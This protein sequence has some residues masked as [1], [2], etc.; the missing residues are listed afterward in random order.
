M[1]ADNLF[2]T[3]DR[4]AKEGEV[5]YIDWQLV[6]PGLVA[7]EFTLAW[8]YLPQEVR[9]NDLDFLKDYHDRLVS[10]NASATVYSHEMLVEDFRTAF[11]VW[12]MTLITIGATTLRIFFEPGGARMK[13][14]WGRT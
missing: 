4:N 11:I 1:R 10:L 14:F 5:T 9:N 6:A 12:W 2:R 13:A 3:R 8:Q 7:P